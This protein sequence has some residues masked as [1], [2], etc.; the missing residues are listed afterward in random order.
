MKVCIGGTFDNL[1]KGHKKL[2][3]NAIRTAGKYG[4]L[5]IGITKGKINSSKKNIQPY[6]NRLS[7]VKSFIEKINLPEKIKV[8]IKPIKDSYGPST[9]GDFD[10]IVVSPETKDP[11]KKINKIRIEKGKKPLKIVVIDYIL[12]EDGNKISSSRIRKGE[13]SKDGKNLKE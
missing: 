11:A 4:Y 10:A 3:L 9:D 2:I 6:Q 12:A 13:I 1:H 7:N 8:N 5:F